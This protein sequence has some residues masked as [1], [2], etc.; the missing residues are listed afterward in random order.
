MELHAVVILWLT[1]AYLAGLGFVALFKPDLARRFLSGFA[2]TTLANLA[3]S[4][5][6][7]LVGLAFILAAGETRNAIVAL[8]IGWF[9]AGSA[10]LMLL[11]PRLHRSFAAKSTASI[12]GVLPM[13][14]AASLALAAVLIWFIA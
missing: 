4:T 11:L 14:G 13:F 12:F 5:V 1:A 3:E 6:R 2:Q 10:L 8:T 7:L 9:L